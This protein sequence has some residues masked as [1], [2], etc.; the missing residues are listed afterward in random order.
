MGSSSFTYRVYMPEQ[1]PPPHLLLS[2]L[3]DLLA[4]LDAV[5]PS[6]PEAVV[7]AF[8]QA[9]GNGGGEPVA[10]LHAWIEAL[11]PAEAQEV[12]AA[13]QALSIVADRADGVYGGFD[14]WPFREFDHGWG[15]RLL[16]VRYGLHTASY[17]QSAEVFL[18]ELVE[19]S[20]RFVDPRSASR[21]RSVLQL[22]QL[23]RLAERQGRFSEARRYLQAIASRGG[24]VPAKL[25]D[26][27]KHLLEA[28]TED[29]A[30]PTSSIAQLLQ[31]HVRLKELVAPIPLQERERRRVEEVNAE[32]EDSMQT[33]VLETPGRRMRNES[34]GRKGAS[35]ESA[36]VSLFRRFFDMTKEQAAAVSNLL[37]RQRGGYQF[38]HDVSFTTT[39]AG[40]GLVRCHVECKNYADP[41]RTSDIADKLLQQK[42]A[43]ATA[44][45]DH[46]I[47]ISPHADPSNDLQQLLQTWEEMDEWGFSVQIWSP[48]SGVRELFA[49]APNVYDALYDGKP[50][51]VEP[52]DVIGEF[53]GRI[54][55]KLRIPSGF[56]KYLH[57]RWRMCFATEDAAH[58]V[59]LL[60]GHAEIG[61][62]DSAGRA[63]DRPLLNV[64]LDWLDGSDGPE[65]LLLLG[66][67]GDG[68]SFF[69]FLLC[70]LLAERFLGAPSDSI[71]PIR[72]ALKDLRQLGSP[73]ALLDKWLRNIGASMAEWS[74]LAATRRTLIVLDGFDEMTTNLDPP[75]VRENLELLTSALESLAGPLTQANKGRRILITSRGRFFDQPRE[76]SALRERLGDPELIRIRP[77]SR[78]E[79]LA[80][81]AQYA[82]RV[83]AMEKLA[84]IQ[85]LY[86]PIGLASKPLFLQMIKETLQDLPN[87]E[88]NARTLYET[89]IDRSLRRKSALLLSKEP[90]ELAADVIE[91]LRRIL[92]RVAMQLHQK[93]VDGVDLREVSDDGDM[94][95]LLWQMTDQSGAHVSRT[96]EHDARMR[97]AVRSLL[98]PLS[99]V[100]D[101][102]KVSF[103][104]RSVAEYFL[105]ATI[106]R[107]LTSH[108][109]ELLREVLSAS[110]LSIETM[111]FTVQSLREDGGDDSVGLLVALAR[112]A[113]RGG[114][115][116]PLGGN[117]LSLAYLISGEVSGANWQNLN[118]DGVRLIGADLRGKSFAGSSLRYANF[119]N[120]DLSGADLSGTDLTGLRIEQTSQVTTV[121]LDADS[122]TVLVGYDDGTI[123]EWT[124]AA[125][126]WTSIVVASGQGHSLRAIVPVT[127]STAVVLAGHEAL[128][129]A[130]TRP[131]WTVS[132]RTPVSPF[133]AS[134]S[135]S[136]DRIHAVH[137]GTSP[138]VAQWNVATDVTSLMAVAP[139]ELVADAMYPLI[140]GRGGATSQRALLSDEWLLSSFFV[141]QHLGPRLWHVPTGRV[142]DLPEADISTFV[143]TT[144]AE[145]TWLILGMMSGQVWRTPVG[146][147]VKLTPSRLGDGSHDGPITCIDA[148]GPN[149]IVTGGV[150]RCVRIWRERERFIQVTPLYLTLRCA[151]ALIEGV[152]GP[153]EYNLL[154]SLADAQGT[155]PEEDAR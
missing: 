110:I 54:A 72:L 89:Y 108:D 97:V 74:E 13:L 57:D 71:Y 26:E 125:S 9:G 25:L 88:F 79:I 139:T 126:G 141:G 11:G 114:S 3:D 123:R 12:M 129:L 1:N 73:E 93:G 103:F 55:P 27:Y 124:Q 67:F 23:A 14:E 106:A 112:T 80:N 40:S 101:A 102:W 149:L 59:A 52:L 85:T 152:E 148:H 60:D 22:E 84:R 81:L 43:A 61:T 100:G 134:L 99:T 6:D 86:D 146:V 47:L 83:G 38:G 58:F 153:A 65:T 96:I 77:L 140:E 18:P 53:L 87:D 62:V 16:A 37:R 154:L 142:W 33:P 30:N 90:F 70:H 147:D 120:A 136:G 109:E 137:S 24:E 121:A 131:E 82:K 145:S 17:W 7:R 2:G 143:V 29:L 66:E 21:L 92:E 50:P 122:L 15:Y 46:W 68:K 144:T 10:L 28:S 105:A 4:D 31:M 75:T 48:Q 69:T 130:R 34:P 51:Q 128:V 35:L 151:D 41:I 91:R 118:L 98:R 8:V 63:I 117:A 95:T 78:V 45:I 49:I 76:E 20:G 113:R 150:D 42:A 138:L 115:V 104:H 116:T 135:R 56:R 133:L 119:D 44:P 32:I 127:A 36:T 107:A 64:V 111:E 155:L 94:A 5:L 132:C 19:T 39:V